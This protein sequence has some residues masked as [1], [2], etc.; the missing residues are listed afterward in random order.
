M[1]RRIVLA[2]RNPGKRRE[3]EPAFQ[4]RGWELLDLDHLGLESPEE[5]ATTFVENALLKAHHAAKQSGLWVLAED[6]G[7]CVPALGG[8]P[9]VYSARFAGDEASDAANNA[10]L[11]AE[12][13]SLAGP[14]RNAYFVCV[15]VLLHGP[16]DPLPVIGTGR[17]VGSIATEAQG[18]DGFGYDPIFLPDA[19][20]GRSAAELDRTQKNR[21]SHRAQALESVL[22][23]L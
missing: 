1:V 23:E 11:L 3:I 19:T 6:S 21:I 18:Q 12:M 22:R 8:R 10:Q 20:P 13:H 14:D 15:M 16:E 7:L 5:T 9:G 17:W 2:S 4:S